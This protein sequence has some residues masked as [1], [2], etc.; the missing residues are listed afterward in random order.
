MQ[1]TYCGAEM[2]DDSVLCTACGRL[3]PE[4]ERSYRRPDPTIGSSR[5]RDDDFDDLLRRDR[6]T[7]RGG[8]IGGGTRSLDGVPERSSRKPRTLILVV[9]GAIA[10]LF[11]F[12]VVAGMYLPRDLTE[13]YREAV[14]WDEQSFDDF[15]RGDFEDVVDA[16]FAYAEENDEAEIRA[17]F[18]E[19]LRE[20]DIED[21]D[22]WSFCYGEAIER[23]T[24]TEVVPY[25][26]DTMDVIADYLEADVEQ[27]VD[28]KA[29]VRF[30]MDDYDTHYDLDA[31]EIDGDWYLIYIW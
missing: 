24:I 26:E 19:P 27:Y 16:Y 6:R 4:Y 14:E 5:R 30:E 8:V 7:S 2:R 23:Y 18:A 1:C 17:L 31:V 22:S 29:A 20:D 15:Q 3:T 21:L 25:D 10:A 12:A 28:I 13:A 9:L 11:A